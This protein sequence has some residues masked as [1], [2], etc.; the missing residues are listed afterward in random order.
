MRAQDKTQDNRTGQT[1]LIELHC[2][3]CGCPYVPTRAAVAR[4][5]E[6]YHRCPVCRPA[7]SDPACEAGNASEARRT[8]DRPGKGGIDGTER[9]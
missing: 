7:D 5:P 6:I 8:A 3:L 1:K 2:R 9:R 4:G